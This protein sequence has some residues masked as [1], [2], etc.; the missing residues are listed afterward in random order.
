M[1]PVSRS[2]VH[3]H[4]HTEYSMLDGAAR[5]G[6]LIEAVAAQGMPA[7]AI[8]DHGNLFGAHDFYNRARAAGITPIIGM[9][10]YVAPGPRT[11]RRK[12]ALPGGTDQILHSHATLL[13]ETTEGLHNLF[14]LA[15]LASMEGFYYHPRIDRELLATYGAGLIGTT[16]CPGGEVPRLLEQGA[17][18]AACQAAADYRDLFGA[19]NYYCELMDH[20]LAIEQRT[21]D[22]L[23]RL[24]ARLGL[25]ALA[26]NDLHYVHRDDA[27]GHDVLLC[28]QTRA[29][30]NDP[31][32]FR[33]EGG[34]EYWLKSAEQMRALFDDSV[35][36]AC[37]NT[38]LIAERAA[39]VVLAEGVDL[40]PHVELSE[41]ETEFSVLTRDVEA[42]LRR[43]SCGHLPDYRA[44]AD[45]EIDVINGKGYAGYFLIVADVVRWA[46]TQGI[47]VG[48]GRGSAAGSLVSYALGITELDPIEHRLL[49][50]RFLNPDRPS[51]PDIDLD[52][53]ERRRGEVIAYVAARYGADRVA[54]MVTYSTI[55]TRAAI[56][57]AGRVL[58]DRPGFGIAERIIGTLPPAVM[59]KDMT[60]AELFDPAHPRAGETVALH[61]LLQRDSSA[62]RVLDAASRIEGLR[63][64]WGVHAAGV[65]LSSRPLLDVLPLLVRQ[66]DGTVLTG[67][68]M[69]A[70]EALGLFKMDFLGLRNL[71]V[72]SDALAHIADPPELETLPLNDPDTYALLASGGTL[73]VF[74]LDGAP[75]RE[76][77]VRMRPDRFADLVAVLALYR[78]GPMG[79]R[80]HHAYADR[81]NGC[82]RVRPIHPELAEPLAEILD[83]TYGLI[84]YQE[85]V[86]A[87]A[88]RAAGYSLGQADLLRRAMGKK[89]RDVLD[90]ERGRFAEGMRVH[91]YGDEAIHIL[92]TT[93]LPF[94]DYA[95]PRAHA[96]GYA[97]ISYWTAWL[98]AHYPAEYMAALLT[99]VADEKDKAALYL[100]ECRRMGLRVS[101]PDVNT[102]GPDFTP[103]D[104]VIR[105]GLNGV[106]NIGS[107]V[108]AAIEQ[109]RPFADFAD[110][111]S[112][113]GP[114]GRNRQAV[115]SLIKAGAFD[116]FGHPRRG[117]YRL[118]AETIEAIGEGKAAEAA[119]QF[120][121]PDGPVELAIPP[122]EWPERHHQVG[123][124]EMLGWY[125]SE[126]VSRP[127]RPF[128]V[129][130][131]A[132]RLTPAVLAALRTIL[133]AHP[134]S[135]Q[136]HL[137]VLN[138]ADRHLLRLPL[139][140]APGP[141]LSTDLHALIGPDALE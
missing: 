127:R 22:D 24:T 84:V 5:V 51:P 108:F 42:G 115:Q 75:M 8:T 11:E 86:M 122:G 141:A 105:F 37:D 136:V 4:T 65:V 126:S 91:G 10:A 32:R 101:V 134:G 41:G 19:G 39:G 79:M 94:A 97:V 73:G 87:I 67:W 93:L 96:A 130:A 26:T 47:R 71:T 135:A 23:L 110:Y 38:L 106:R 104:G 139:H 14:R 123:E 88:Q 100:T 74:Q 77:L 54:Q 1:P 64:G 119:G 25:P 12:M 57:D 36:D 85:Q 3:L 60:L 16:G 28:V 29:T 27:Y 111:L 61:R 132:N 49:F 2:F 62:A 6:P 125:V 50:E 103:V 46:K 18:D 129:C 81:K 44:R 107:P 102:S 95:F 89:K 7:L 128:T 30:L 133:L 131:L 55:R 58:F 116:Q 35:P 137:A 121:E 59:G 17:Y 56:K 138:G 78:P 118:A 72:I 63:R 13:A 120:A 90:A 33:F 82:E 48:P 92:W 68:D 70:C 69:H 52:F 117:L 113:V 140:V 114:A 124:G 31:T 34:P 76:L 21:R 40:M 15:S 66:S 43:R 99:S 83:E 80:A 20:G 45:Y 9:E 98:K 112:R 109:A 53:D